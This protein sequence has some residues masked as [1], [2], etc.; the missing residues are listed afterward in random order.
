MNEKGIIDSFYENGVFLDFYQILEVSK[1]ASSEEIKK[2]Y[3][4]LS[5]LYHPDSKLGNVQK[6]QQIGT[7][8][9]ILKNDETRKLY[10]SYYLNQGKK[11]TTNPTKNFHEYSQ[12]KHTFSNMNDSK[13]CFSWNYIREILRKCHY[14]DTEIDGFI[15]WCQRNYISISSG[16]ELSSKLREYNSF[17]YET[18]QVKRAYYNEPKKQNY[19]FT[20]SSNF[21]YQL[22][23][24]IFYR[25][26]MIRQ[27]VIANLFSQYLESSIS[28]YPRVSNFQVYGVYPARMVLYPYMP[29]TRV[30]FYSSPKVK[31]YF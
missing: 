30:V 10:D 21:G 31:Y 14:S 11:S 26:M 8:Y 29:T 12:P 18:N 5:K 25:Q 17:N 7:A 3:H 9:R 16:S 27:M 15:A 22:F 13:D 24:S 6:M 4:R 1:N 19:V 28:F 23:D 20:S 2:N